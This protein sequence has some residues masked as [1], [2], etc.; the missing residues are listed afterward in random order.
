MQTLE[1]DVSVGLERG[2]RTTAEFFLNVGSVRALR[3]VG[4]FGGVD[5]IDQF[6][7]KEHDDIATGADDFHFVPFAGLFSRV[8]ARGL[9]PVDSAAGVIVRG[10]SEVVEELN[11]DRVRNPI[12]FVGRLDQESSVRVLR[13]AE[14]KRANKRGVLLLRP[15]HGVFF[16]AKAT[17]VVEIPNPFRE[18]AVLEVRAKERNRG[19]EEVVAPGIS[20]NVLD[21]LK[22]VVV[23]AKRVRAASETSAKRDGE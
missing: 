18:I 7:V 4:P 17:V 6:A 22:N 10:L 1:P 15:D 2:E 11:L 12:L 9:E 23:V 20:G 14:L 5:R 3:A 19:A 8:F 21:V 13:K 16:R